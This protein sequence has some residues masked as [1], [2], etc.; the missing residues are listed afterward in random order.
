LDPFPSFSSW[1]PTSG[2]TFPI[3]SSHCHGEAPL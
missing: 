2:K 1:P 3:T